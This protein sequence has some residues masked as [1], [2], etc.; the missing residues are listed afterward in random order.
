MGEVFTVSSELGQAW[1]AFL[2]Q[3][4][5]A[6]HGLSED[7]KGDGI[8]GHSTRD[9]VHIDTL[10]CSGLLDVFHNGW[11]EIVQPAEALPAGQFLQ[12]GAF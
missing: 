3:I 12:S 9:A 10:V 2:L 7:C 8:H 5:S 11:Q 4:V 6:A 1:L